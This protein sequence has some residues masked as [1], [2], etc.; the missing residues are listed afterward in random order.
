MTPAIRVEAVSK[1]YLH[2]SSQGWIESFAGRLF[3]SFDRPRKS[4]LKAQNIWGLRD[5][6][7]EIAQGEFVGVIGMPGCGKSTLVKI[8]IGVTTPTSGRVI[9]E[10]RMGVFRGYG[11][12]LHPDLTLR[13][14]TLLAGAA[15][16]MKDA[17][18]LRHLDDLVASAKLKPADAD[19]EVER[20]SQKKRMRLAFSIAAHLDPDIL[21]VDELWTDEGFQRRSLETMERLNRQGRTIVFVSHHLGDVLNR[22][23]RVIWLHEGRVARVGHADEIV[24]RYRDM[25]RNPSAHSEIVV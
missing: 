20:L 12:D 10:G 18:V 8:L 11:R 6:S 5:V 9:I 17:D 25:L 23:A 13:E 2:P 7:F 14:N 24:E 4:S 22:C 16:R 3:G 21:V 19:V 15:R 1:C